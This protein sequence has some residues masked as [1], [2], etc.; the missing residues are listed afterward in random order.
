MS[1]KFEIVDVRRV[2]VV[3][4]AAYADL[5]ITDDGRRRYKQ[6]PHTIARFS[7]RDEASRWLLENDFR[8][9][10]GRDSQQD[11]WSRK[12]DKDHYYQMGEIL[13]RI[14]DTEEICEAR[15]RHLTDTTPITKGKFTQFEK[16]RSVVELSETEQLDEEGK[17]RIRK[18]GRFHCFEKA[19]AWLLANGFEPKD[20]RSESWA[21]SKNSVVRILTTLEPL[22]VSNEVAQARVELPSDAVAA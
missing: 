8:K 9:H 15:V 17:I 4:Q 10:E 2:P 6:F 18:I 13:E 22:H 11:W 14:T 1:N 5:I 21:R 7:T 3:L 16:R 20:K 12:G 19:E